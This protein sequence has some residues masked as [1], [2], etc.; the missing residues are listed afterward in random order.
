MT[1]AKAALSLMMLGI[2][3]G[4]PEWVAAQSNSQD[5][6]VYAGYLFGDRLLEQ[7]LSGG[8]PRLDDDGIF[9]ARYTYH[10]T[11]DLGIQLSTG[12]SPNRAAHVASGASNLGLTTVDLDFELDAPLS[13]QV[14]G[15]QLI[16]YAVIGT[17]YAWAELDDPFFGVTG[18][19]GSVLIKNCNGYTANAGLGIKY[20]VSD[21]LF[22]DL[23]G[24]YRYMSKLVSVFGQGLSTSEATVGIGYR[25]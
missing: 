1:Y 24:R 5:V 18:S 19:D 20:Y 14:I 7:P 12:Y 10:W 25:F 11:D 3:V 15:Q 4:S 2:A 8:T 16:P 13:A 9:G 23:D 22:I 6:Q 21:R 17:G